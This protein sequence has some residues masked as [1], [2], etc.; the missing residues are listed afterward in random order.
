MQTKVKKQTK[1]FV[2]DN[3]V[4]SLKD[5]SRGFAGSV[6]SDLAKDSI[7]TAWDQM[8]G[9]GKGRSGD[10][11][12]GQEIVLNREKTEEADRRLHLEPALDYR[13]EI[14]QREKQSIVE[15]GQEIKVKIEEVLIELKKLIKSSEE[16]R[17]EFREVEVEELVE[18]PGKYHLNFLEWLLEIVRAARS[19]V[20]DGASWLEAFYSKR[21]K[22]KYW[23]M[24]KKHGTSFG[25]SQ[26]RSVSTQSG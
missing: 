14:L 12:E 24:F 4:E 18:K 16:L 6:T 9:L 22:R 3:P 25:L 10:L 20:E 5:L 7:K 1:N 26:E 19:T 13:R 2:N 15:N 23:N 17:V 8:L 21:N 11:E